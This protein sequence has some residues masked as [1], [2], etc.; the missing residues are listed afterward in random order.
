MKCQ[1]VDIEM[2]INTHN[3]KQLHMPGV[4]SQVFNRKSFQVSLQQRQV[5]CDVYFSIV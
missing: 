3:S 4:V 5:H 1:V 2:T